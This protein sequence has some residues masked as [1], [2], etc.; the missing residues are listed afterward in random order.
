MDR[1]FS[2]ALFLVVPLLAIAGGAWW[3]SARPAPVEAVDPLSNVALDQRLLAVEQ[4]LATLVRGQ[5]RSEQRLADLEARSRVQRD[6]LLGWGQR[7]ALLEDS[8]QQAANA[9]QGAPGTRLRLDE[10]DLLLSFA[11][12]RIELA[13]DA[14]GARRA[15]ALADGL[16]S[17]LTA[18]QFVN[19]RQSLAQEQ[20]ALAALPPDPRL[21]AQAAVDAVEAGLDALESQPALPPS[22]P[23]ASPF[24]RLIDALVDIRPAGAQDLIAPADRQRGE[25]ALRLE[26]SLA[27]IAIERRDDVG[28]AAAAGRAQDWMRRLY[29]AGPAL[30]AALE[31]LGGLERTSLAIATPVLG[32]TLQQLRSQRRAEGGA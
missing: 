6:E 19:L 24:D 11:E 9:P 22:A 14:E 20:A 32:T 23:A 31:S 3:W 30:D 5:T 21:A 28:L 13:G 27:R 1:R 10:V 12:A 26:L 4:S 15:Y 8:V 29:S 2:R 18:P 25:A 16:L 17:A 7:T